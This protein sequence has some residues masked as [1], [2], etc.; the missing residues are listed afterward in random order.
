MSHHKATLTSSNV[1]LGSVGTTVDISRVEKYFATT[2]LA[3]L[4]ITYKC[5]DPD[6]GVPIKATITIV[7]KPGRKQ[8]PSSYFA[9]RGASHAKNCSRQTK[10]SNPTS[11][12]AVTS[13]LAHPNRQLAPSVWRNPLA[14]NAGVTSLVSVT[15]TSDGTLSNNGKGGRSR[16][17]DGTSQKSSQ[18]MEEF[19]PKWKYMT[20]AERQQN[21]FIAPWNLGGTYFIAFSPLYLFPDCLLSS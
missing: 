11:T 6:C 21:A 9:A 19:C 3:N 18:K 12:S 4:G 2:A 14:A 5:A 10:E 16:T 17:G 1:L 13:K 15:D 20:V 8:S 7:S